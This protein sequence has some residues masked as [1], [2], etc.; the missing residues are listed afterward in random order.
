MDD[1][2]SD[3]KIKLTQDLIYHNLSNVIL[4]KADARSKIASNSDLS[5]LYRY[6][7]GT[8]LYIALNP[9]F[10]FIKMY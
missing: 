4:I 5:Q 6:I 1:A 9:R 7:I 10:Y 8:A 2:F 3:T